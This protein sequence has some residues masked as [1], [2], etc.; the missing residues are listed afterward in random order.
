MKNIVM[1]F[2]KG[3]KPK[4]EITA[5]WII[6]TCPTCEAMGLEYETWWNK[7]TLKPRHAKG[8][9]NPYQ[10]SAMVKILLN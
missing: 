1:D 8:I 2:S 4:V 3:Y 7:E 6:F 5:E 10:H 9:D